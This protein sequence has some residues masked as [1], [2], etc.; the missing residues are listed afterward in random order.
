MDLLMKTYIY[1]HTHT[2]YTC[3]YI[4]IYT[5]TYVYNVYGYWDFSGGSVVKKNPPAVQEPQK[6]RV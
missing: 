5:H 1:T 2:L 3:V 6:M 4:H